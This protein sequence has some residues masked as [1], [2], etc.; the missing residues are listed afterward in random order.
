MKIARALLCPSLLGTLT[1][2][3]PAAAQGCSNKN[4]RMVVAFPT[5]A[6]YLLAILVSERLRKSLGQTAVPDFQ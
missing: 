2:A 3:L 1:G 4:I 5:G 6:S